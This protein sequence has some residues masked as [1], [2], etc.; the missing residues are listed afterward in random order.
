MLSKMVIMDNN[1]S[2]SR[3]NT[4]MKKFI[5]S[6]SKHFCSSRLK[7]SKR[8]CRLCSSRGWLKLMHNNNKNVNSKR[9]T[10][11]NSMHKLK[12]TNKLRGN[13]K[14]PISVM[15]GSANYPEFKSFGY[16]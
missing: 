12:H 1:N 15:Q 14:K 8:R 5:S 7:E 2:S 16:Q 9:D 3:E 10:L 4:P 11:N 6:N 13:R